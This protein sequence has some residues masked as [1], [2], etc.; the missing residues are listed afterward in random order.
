M[1]DELFEGWCV[2]T[3]D[4]A[5][6]ERLRES[7]SSAEG[8]RA[9]A[10]HVR[11]RSVLLHLAARRARV[12]SLRRTTRRHRPRP[13]ASLA[14]PA[15]AA[16][17]ALVGILFVASLASSPGRSR[18]APLSP[19]PMA[20][21]LEE[22]AVEPPP[23]VARAVRVEAPAWTPPPPPPVIRRA[24]AAPPAP[25]APAPRGATVAAAAS[26]ERGEPE[27]DGRPGATVPA[28]AGLRTGKVGAVLLW[29]DGTLVEL[30]AESVLR[31]VQ[32]RGR[33][34]VLERGAL[35][36]D[37]TRQPAGEPMSIATP[38]GE[39]VVLGTS[40][41][42]A[43]G[44]DG[45]RLE[46]TEGKVR[47]TR[48]KDRKSVEV[49][50]GQTATDG[51]LVARPLVSRGAAED[52]EA[53]PAWSSTYHAKWGGAAA[54][55]SGNGQKGAGLAATRPGKGSSVVAL[56]FEVP[57]QTAVDVSLFMRC[58][59]FT[60]RAWAECGWRLG[61]HAASDFDVNPEAWTPVKKLG[62]NPGEQ[63][64]NGNAW[65]RYVGTAKTGAATRIT[66]AFKAGSFDGPAPTVGF[67]TLRL[68]W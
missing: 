30:A 16:A 67:D 27:I 21:P 43:T 24:E 48:E 9:F 57:A 1:S 41:R 45:M 58:P 40:F 26:V 66:V 54:W 36:A 37:V 3:L 59:R 14:W 8:R 52:F 34:F 12:P 61:S 39:V 46:V 31:D 65:T 51:D 29:T 4:P 7:L 63:N 19:P 44:R 28:G 42:L 33:R 2:G 11:E 5:G 35:Q 13:A 17:G 64:G 53:M 62:S 38:Q 22:P 56:V 32:P 68:S 23:P 10:E 25:M 15:A 60:G 49:A 20:R 55:A 6:R 50:A 47:L 18:P